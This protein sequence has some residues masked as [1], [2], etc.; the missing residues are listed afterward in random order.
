MAN[1]RPFPDKNAPDNGIPS[2]KKGSWQAWFQLGL[3]TIKYFVQM[4]NTGFEQRTMFCFKLFDLHNSNRIIIFEKPW[5][6]NQQ[7]F[8]C[9]GLAICHVDK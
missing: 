4:Q 8:L 2:H 9:N 6:G 3:G 1:Y 7:G 5:H